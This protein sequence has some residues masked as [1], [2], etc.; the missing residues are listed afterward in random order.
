MVRAA[1]LSERAEVT[2]R[3]R[4]RTNK[5]RLPSVVSCFSANGKGAGRRGRAARA[6]RAPPLSNTP[7][8]SAQLDRNRLNSPKK[9]GLEPDTRG[10]GEGGTHAA[11]V[12]PGRGLGAPMGGGGR[13][14]L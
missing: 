1:V 11:P 13:G 10:D 2:S 6:Q 8:G 5:T 12:G 4:S 14:R 7:A 3:G 9:T